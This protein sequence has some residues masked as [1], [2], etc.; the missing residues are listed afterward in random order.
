MGLSAVVNNEHDSHSSS[1]RYF[2]VYV[3]FLHAKTW[4]VLWTCNMGQ[5]RGPCFSASVLGGRGQVNDG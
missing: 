1:I 3:N 5:D 4:A 2:F